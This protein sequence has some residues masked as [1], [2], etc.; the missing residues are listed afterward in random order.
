MPVA[1]KDLDALINKENAERD[2]QQVKFEQPPEEPVLPEVIPSE[3][4]GP[5]DVIAVGEPVQ[6]ASF[7][8]V[9]VGGAKALQKATRAAEARVTEKG[10]PEIV[11]PV[12]EETVI[13]RASP[14]EEASFAADLGV[15][16]KYTKGLNF[17]AIAQATGEIDLAS[18]LQSVKDNNVAL[19]E[20]ARRGTI[21][22]ENLL[23][24]AEKGG[25]DNLVIEFM[26]RTPGSPAI[27]ED[28]LA[29]LIG[30]KAISK[31]VLELR[32]EAID[33]ADPTAK[34]AI[35]EQASNLINA[36]ARLYAN[37]SGAVSEGGRLLFAS[38]EAQRLGIA[39][40]GRS[41]E[42]AALI[43]SGNMMD[44]ERYLDAYAALPDAASQARFVQSRWWDKPA[45]FVA[46]SFLNAILTSP[47]T[48]SVNVAGNSAFMM[49]KG[50]E[51]T[52][53]GGI[54][55]ARS[56]I[57]GN[58]ERVF[59]REGLIQLDSLRAGFKDAMLVAGKTMLTG[60]PS[61]A[62]KI[63]VRNKR[64]IGTTDDFSEIFNMY[65]EGNFGAAFVN[66]F[67]VYN[68]MGFRFLTT[69]DEFFKAIAYRASVKKQAV[70]QGASMYD[71]VIQRGGSVIDAR[72]AQAEEEARVLSS[73]PKPIKMKATEAA[74]E[75]TFQG[76][77]GKF[78]GGAEGLMSH[79]AVKIFG[80]PFYK[81]PVNIM[82]EAFRRTPFAAGHA[83]YTAINKGGREA[84]LA[85]ARV[86]TGTGIMSMFA[87]TAMGLDSP[88]KSVII[89]GS[90]PTDP[91][92][93]QAMMRMNIQPFSINIKQANGEY[94][95]ITYSRFDPISGMLAMAAD[96]GYYAQYSD[97]PEDLANLAAHTGLAL[98]N[99]SMEMP[100]LQGV[101]DLS[102]ALVN[103]D[104][105]VAFEQVRQLMAERLTTA[106]SSALPTVSSLAATAERVADPAASSAL[107]PEIGLAGEDPTQLPPELRGFYSALQKMKAR[108]P[109]FSDQVEP[110]L[111]LWGETV[112]QGKGAG[113]E[114]V[115]PVR[116][117]DAKYEDVDREFME[118]GDGVQMPNKK[119]S[120][121]LLNAAQYNRWI[122]LMNKMDFRGNMPD[123]DGYMRG[124]TLLDSLNNEIYKNDYQDDIK[125]DKLERLKALVSAAKTQAR[126]RLFDEYPDLADRIEAAR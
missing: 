10:A 47:V 37:I 56:T 16:E 77:L 15:T 79:P 122:T 21:S 72:K 91:E 120:G 33:V 68:R 42:L 62:T 106:V 31:R 103:P 54:G 108:N 9:F 84:D 112:K 50:V 30:A 82:K 35:F 97:D 115:S 87:Y 58:K 90:G 69:E 94:K 17:P 59:I 18:H 6:V 45:D 80:V 22:Y 4:V 114:W 98:Y 48:H 101:S 51:E 26:K 14:E 28:V 55:L 12:G 73:P 105:S 93:R 32:Q 61:S 63:D 111:N 74:K 89:T 24:A 70:Q 27:A 126:D 67:G 8:D 88:D 99:Y 13:R 11:A 113:Y 95:S 71:A 86:A 119:I 85:I 107:M 46:E 125:E 65:R 92:A 7:K 81:T 121:V 1:P 64:A 23:K 43:Q 110:K 118:L 53:A 5:S 117:M 57:T 116:I 25:I 66:T 76:D 102:A 109:L 38:R 44:F 123:D 3:P 60:E 83:F 19:F 20:Q 29:G 96:F 41:D 34:Q 52:V 39:E 49:L 100:F 75:L 36:E 78:A 2:L 40:G 104:P 124:Q